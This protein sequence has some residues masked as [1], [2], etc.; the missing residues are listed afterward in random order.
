MSISFHLMPYQDL[1]GL[2]P[3]HE[4]AWYGGRTTSSIR[5]M[6][7]YYNDYLDQLAAA[8]ERASTASASTSTTKRVR[9]EPSP[10]IIA[11]MLV[12]RT[13]RIK[14]AIVGNALPLYDPPTRVA[15]EIAMLDCISGGR[16]ISGQV[17][18]GGPEYFSFSINPAQARTRFA[19]AHEII[20]RAWTEPGPFSYY[21]EHYKLRYVNLWPKPLQKPHPPIW[22]PG[23]GSIGRD[24]S[25]SA[26]RYMG[27]RHF[28]TSS[29]QELR[30]QGDSE[31]RLQAHPSRW[32]LRPIYFPHRTQAREEWREILDF[33]TTI[34]GLTLA[35]P[36]YT[37]VKSALRVY[38]ALQDG[39][40]FI[41]SCQ[42]WDDVERGGFAVVG[43]PATVAQ[44]LTEWSKR[45]GCG[46]LLGLFQFGNMPAD[47]ARENARRYAEAVMPVVNRALPNSK[48]PMPA[49]IPFLEAR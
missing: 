45:I 6:H 29:H 34:P 2:C 37:S 17:I 1:P 31:G 16:I 3:K 15:E 11:S 4:S 42:S 46:N 33:C 25:P 28:S 7:G 32:F 12:M 27:L 35:P 10:N 39:K 49:A 47:K 43:S 38:R 21:G 18:G 24:S 5:R 36:G 8:E 40:T 9:S 22:I 19:E 44:K 20:M 14:I 41:N 23:A 30:V 13:T 48:V 26:I